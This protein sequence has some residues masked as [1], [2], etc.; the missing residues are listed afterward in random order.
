MCPNAFGYCSV[1]T[2]GT[3]SVL[4][5]FMRK[6][7]VEITVSMLWMMERNRSCTSHRRKVVEDGVSLPI[8]RAAFTVVRTAELERPLIGAR[9]RE[10][11]R[12]RRRGNA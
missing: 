12:R 11:R 5:A 6:E 8:R 10:R 2:M 4:A 9:R 7:E 3:S 1:A